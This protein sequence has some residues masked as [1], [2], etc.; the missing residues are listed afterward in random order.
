MAKLDS[1][2]WRALVLGGIG[3]STLPFA[4]ITPYSRRPTPRE[5]PTT[6]VTYAGCGGRQSP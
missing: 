5:G 1:E 3:T 4:P 2:V 6:I